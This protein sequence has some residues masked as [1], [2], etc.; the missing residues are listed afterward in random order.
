M[1][2]FELNK[3][4][5]VLK[6]E[7]D[8]FKF[9]KCLYPRW[10]ND[11]K[12]DKEIKNE[13]KTCVQALTKCLRSIFNLILQLVSQ[14]DSSMESLTLIGKESM[15]KMKNFQTLD[16]VVEEWSECLAKKGSLIIF[17]SIKC[18]QKLNSLRSIFGERDFFS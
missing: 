13:L 1:S 3:I 6:L 7:M 10:L 12:K 2:E 15:T 17:E 9:S 14:V 4:D 5:L 16:R 11:K 8:M 18:L